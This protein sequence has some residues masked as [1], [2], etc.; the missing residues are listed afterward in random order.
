MSITDPVLRAVK[1]YEHRPCITRINSLTKS[2][3]D[4]N[5]KH[6]C[7]WKIKEKVAQVV[8]SL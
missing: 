3:K 5:F 6:F 7:L 2:S 8:S 4:I 1:K